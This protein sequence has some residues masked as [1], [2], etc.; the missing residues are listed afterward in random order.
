MW[1][2]RLVSLKGVSDSFPIPHETAS[3]PWSPLLPYVGPRWIMSDSCA[4]I[5]CSPPGSP[6][7]GFP[8]QEYWS[9]L[10]FPAPGALPNPGIKPGSP[11]SCT[12]RQILYRLS[13]RGSR[14]WLHQTR[15]AGQ[16]GQPLHEPVCHLLRGEGKHKA[17][18]K[19]FTCTE[20]GLWMFLILKIR[21]CEINPEAIGSVPWCNKHW[22]RCMIIDE[23][24]ADAGKG[25]RW[26]TA[27]TW[28]ASQR[29]FSSRVLTDDG[30]KSSDKK[31]NQ[32]L[33][34]E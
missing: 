12:C 3:H 33:G 4:S 16:P 24:W 2:V 18:Y 22:M 19:S 27:N 20:S 17:I 6:S 1:L 15:S 5:N 9:A 7:T 11:T 13:H 31:K 30:S 26:N 10:P 34:R 25:H 29:G 28:T 23:T 32:P 21:T 14:V 8:R